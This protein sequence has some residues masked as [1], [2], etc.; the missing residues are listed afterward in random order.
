MIKQVDINKVLTA[1]LKRKGISTD[2]K[3]GRVAVKPEPKP[4]DG[5]G[6]DYSEDGPMWFWLCCFVQANYTQTYTFTL[7]FLSINLLL[8]YSIP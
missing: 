1:T 7:D 3:G 8:L 4:I 6:K 5:K 2:V